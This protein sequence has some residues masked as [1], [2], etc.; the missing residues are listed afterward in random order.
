MSAS[1]ADG[2][3]I[4]GH[5][6]ALRDAYVVR[7]REQLSELDALL[8][9]GDRREAMRCAHKMAGA[10]GSYGLSEIGRGARRI[11]QALE[12]DTTGSAD[13]L[14]AVVQSMRSVLPN[15]EPSRLEPALLVLEPDADVRAACLRVAEVPLLF[16]SDGPEALALAM[17]RPLLGVVFPWKSRALL[18][19][20]RA[21]DEL[22]SIPVVL[23][24]IRPGQ[25]GSV[26]EKTGALFVLPSPVGPDAVRRAT[27]ALSESER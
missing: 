23:T 2:A 19:S 12:D 9:R 3:D 27:R 16:A 15:S 8:A 10:A 17:D 6:R 21:D 22:C 18:R 4:E 7:L 14:L 26:L 24:E 20:L 1:G 11:E 5:L 13:E 25:E